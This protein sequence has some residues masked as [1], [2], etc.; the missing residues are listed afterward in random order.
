MSESRWIKP[1]LQFQT[2]DDFGGPVQ[3][4]PIVHEPTV[5]ELRNMTKSEYV[6][7]RRIKQ[8][9]GQGIFDN[10]AMVNEVIARD[11]RNEA[12]HLVTTGV[13]I[14]PLQKWQAARQRYIHGDDSAYD[15]ML[16]AV[17]LEDGD[18]YSKTVD[19]YSKTVDDY[20]KADTTEVKA[21]QMT[22]PTTPW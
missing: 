4:T 17:R 14:I 20:A 11:K 5:H 10:S 19:D 13:Q 21:V 18:A 12:L 7:W 3:M 22:L 9:G 6:A 8:H 15:T 16:A 1:E 2:L